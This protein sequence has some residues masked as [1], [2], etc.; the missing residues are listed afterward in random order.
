MFFAYNPLHSYTS[1]LKRNVTGHPYFKHVLNLLAT[2]NSEAVSSLT[3]LTIANP[4]LPKMVGT[5]IH[6]ADLRVC[7]C[8]LLT[9][10]CPSNLSGKIPSD[11]SCSNRDSH[12]RPGDALPKEV[13]SNIENQFFYSFQ[14]LNFTL[15]FLWI[16]SSECCAFKPQR[17]W[18]SFKESLISTPPLLIS[19]LHFPFRSSNSI[20]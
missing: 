19:C 12:L 6:L 16:F 11:A 17:K 2:A 15:K 8:Y 9:T 5:I 20:L 4:T 13:S 7:G 10:P 3:T 18:Q 1:A 14:S